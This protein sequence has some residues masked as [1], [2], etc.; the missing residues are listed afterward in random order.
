MDANAAY[1]VI[2][3]A[4]GVGLTWRSIADELAA[5][6]L[7]IPSAPSVESIA[8]LLGAE[9]ARLPRP[10]VIIGASS[11]AVV[12]L[13]IARAVHVDALLLTA[14]GFGIEVS[15][16]LLRWLADD[17][18][19]IH[20]KISRL[21]LADGGDD[22]EK[23]AS[24]VADYDACGA[25]LHVDQLTAIARHRPTSGVARPPGFVLWGDK[26]RSVPLEHHLQ[27]AEQIGGAVVPLTRCGHQVHVDRPDAVL[28]WARRTAA[29]VTG[30]PAGRAAPT[31]GAR[32]DHGKE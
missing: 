14:S 18:P 12:A 30:P 2:P 5:V 17:P 15:E 16:R 13:E 22:A 31:G 7:P 6:V 8:Q 27:L 21:G 32:L 1:A 25:S 11:G 3:G 26:D 4:G 24:V 10:R 29:L 23:L 9:V 19:G 28:L 20:D